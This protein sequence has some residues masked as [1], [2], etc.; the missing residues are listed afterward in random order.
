MIQAAR[1]RAVRQ[2][3]W[4]G[5]KLGMLEETMPGTL[6]GTLLAIR[7]RRGELFMLDS[8][9]WLIERWNLESDRLHEQSEDTVQFGGIF[10]PA[11]SAS[12]A[13]S[14]LLGAFR[15]LQLMVHRIV[16]AMSGI[17]QLMQPVVARLD[18]M[19]PHPSGIGY[20]QFNQ[21]YM[22]ITILRSAANPPPLV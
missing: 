22:R 16:A 1:S 20:S 5:S 4:L 8:S 19:L 2:P 17:S 14:C 12:A 10:V 13:I 9:R 6:A 3:E 11:G 15:T 21:E 18:L 7:Q